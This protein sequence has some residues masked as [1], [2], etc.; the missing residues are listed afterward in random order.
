MIGNPVLKITAPSFAKFSI[1][2]IKLF[3]FV[4]VIHSNIK[5]KTVSDATNYS[6]VLVNMLLF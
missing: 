5:F 4:K 3:Y 6:I 2:P 1:Q